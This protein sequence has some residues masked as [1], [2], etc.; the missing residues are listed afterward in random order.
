[1]HP[2]T[3]PLQFVVGLAA[4]GALIT[5]PSARACAVLPAEGAAIPSLAVERV[6]VLHDAERRLEHFVREVRFDGAAGA[7]AFVVPTPT[8]PEVAAVEKAPFDALAQTFP[9]DPPPEPPDPDSKSA[10][11]AVAAAPE[12]VEVLSVQQVGKFTA[13]VLAANDAAGLEKW[14]TDNRIAVPAGGR[15]WLGHYVALNHFFTAF[16]YEAPRAI[17]AS[18]PSASP[19][20]P[21]PP[22]AAEPAGGFATPP[23]G[24]AP[25][26]VPLA[27]DTSAPATMT[28]ETVRLTFAASTPYFP[29]LEPARG[30]SASAASH[31]MQVWLVSRQRRAPRLRR[32]AAGQAPR[33]AWPWQAGVAY[34][35]D[36][37]VVRGALGELAPLAPQD[38]MLR[39]QTF[40]DPR[41]NRDGWGDI[42]FPAED[43]DLATPA[44]AAGLLGD[45]GSLIHRLPGARRLVASAS[46]CRP[47]ALAAT[48]PCPAPRAAPTSPPPPRSSPRWP[49]SRAVVAAAEQSHRR[50]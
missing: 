17:A 25:V 50:R 32:F 27:P 33:W 49:A 14:L 41:T 40:R 5:P 29:Y 43:A 22:N 34:D 16:R 47:A 8:K 3:R 35:K 10:G 36:A 12:S 2:A 30:A 7:F 1:M 24:P 46:V 9:I 18:S 31:E 37:V 42:V 26:A 11:M 23:F 20:H 44:V 6:L 15:A 48:A 21:P 4:C 28:S 19:S 38:G 45:L 39:V 13:F